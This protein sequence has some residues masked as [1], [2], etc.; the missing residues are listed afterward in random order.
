VNL[1]PSRNILKKLMKRFQWI[2]WVALGAILLVTVLY[3]T[4]LADVPFHPDESTHIFM[5]QDLS[6]NP[7]TLAWDGELPLSNE[8][9]LR[10]IDAPLARTLIGVVRQVFSIPTLDADWNWSLDWDENL[11]AGALPSRQQLIG[12]RSVMV[13]LMPF[14]LWLFYLAFKKVLSPI[15]SLIVVMLLGLNPLFLLHGRRAMSESPLIFGIALFTWAVTRDERNPWLIGLSLAIAVNAKLSALG[16]FPAGL[17]ALIYLPKDFPGVKKGVL[18]LLKAGTVVLT[19][20]VLLNPFY[21]KHP[22][23][24]LDAGIQARLSLAAEQQED[25][26]GQYGLDRQMLRTTIPGLI[27][28]TYLTPPQIEEVG[29]YLEETEESKENYLSNPLHNWGRNLIIG[30]IMASISIIGVGFAFWRFPSKNPED[31][32]HILVI[33]LAT[34]GLIIFTIFLLP[35]QRYVLA[36]LPYAFCWIGFG[37]APLFKAIGKK[38]NQTSP[39]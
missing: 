22:L 24:A 32:S 38:P 27:L 13:L 25:H 7:L 30:S 15:P 6:R 8:E 18:D 23:D 9:R 11:S 29:N 5:S 2:D 14:S 19:A 3:A 36:I 37:L 34:V 10:A 1:I 17:L 35:W 39:E 4:T 16:L 12:S 28:N 31:K 20:L 26:L 33:A 21:W